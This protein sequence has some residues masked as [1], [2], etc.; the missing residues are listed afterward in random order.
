MRK[1]FEKYF[2]DIWNVPNVLTMLRLALIPVFVALFATGHEKLALLTFLVASFTDFL[3]GY[4]ARKHNQ[5]TAFGKLMDPL[6]DKV[7][8]CTA[9]LCQG[10]QGVFPWT[11]IA[12]VMGKEL[13]MVLGGVFMLRNDVVVYSNMLGK[14]AQCCFI[15]ALTLSFFH[16]EFLAWG[17]PLD[18]IILWVSVGMTICALIDYAAGAFKTLRAKR[19]AQ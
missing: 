10:I 18:R 8:V 3:D 1:L 15:L 4:L 2:T 13:L 14:L 12:I 19:A 6:A 9:L 17:F 11:A 5:I 16:A 7:M